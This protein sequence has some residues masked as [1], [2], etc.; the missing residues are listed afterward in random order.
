M[1]IR[2]EK[3]WKFDIMNIVKT[4]ENGIGWK[5][6]A[7]LL[8][9]FNFQFSIFTLNAQKPGTTPVKVSNEKQMIHGRKYYV[10]IVERGQTV[11]SISK[12]YKVSSYD[13]VTHVDI[14]ALHPGDTVWLPFRGQFADSEEQPTPTPAPTPTTTP[15]NTVYVHDTSYINVPYAVHDTVIVTDTV[16]LTKYVTVHDTTFVDIPHVVHDTAIVTN[17]VTQKEYVTVHDTIIVTD[18]VTLTKY[19]TVHD[20]THVNVPQVV[21]DT[22]TLTK[23]ETLRDTIIVKDTV[24]LTK[25][26]TVH[27]TTHVNV[28]QIVRDTVTLTKYETVHDTTYVNVPQV[29]HDTVTLTKYVTVH[30]TTHVNVPQVVRDT[31]TLTKYETVRDTVIVKDTVTLTQYVTVHDT[32][33]ID[34]PHVVH[35]TTVVYDTVTLT[36]NVPVHDTTYITLRD[37]TFVTDTVTLTQYVTVHDTTHVDIPHIVHD[38]TII[39][40]TVTLTKYVPVHDTT[41][42]DVPHDATIVTDTVTLTEYVSVHDTTYIDVHDTL[43]VIDTV[44]LTKSIPVHDTTYIDVPYAVHDTTF[45]IDTVDFA[46]ASSLAFASASAVTMTEYMPASQPNASPA[47]PTT[48][49]PQKQVG[50]TLKIALLMPLHLNE[51]DE[52][53]TTKFDIEQRGKKSYRQ[54]EFIEFYEGI[55]LALEQLPSMGINTRV[56]LNVVDVLDNSAESVEQAFLSHNVA[57]SDVV[58]ALLFRDAFA[59][60][61]ELSQ[62]AGIHIVNPMSTRSE[63]CDENSYMVKIQPSLES[64]VKAILDNMKYERPN[65][66][67]YVIYGGSAD[68]PILNELKHQLSERGDIKYTLFNWNQSS[69]LTSTL[70]NTPGCNV[71][72]IY[73]QNDNMRVYVSNLLN[74]L[75]AIKSNSPTLYTFS[76]WT[77]DYADVD[78]SQL[79]LLNYHTFTQNWDLSNSIHVDFLKKFRNRF[80]SEPTSILA[81]TGYDL[82]SY[83]VYGMALRKSK[84]WNE[85]GASMSS[86]IHP[87]RLERRR[88]GLENHQPQLYRMESLHFVPAETSTR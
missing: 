43:V 23:Y 33:H 9:L 63:I 20:T 17:T 1:G 73:E 28:P 8:V 83:I 87:L 40:D 18:T 26:V 3:K 31:M 82:T 36:K 46:S 77:R 61:A 70:K 6:L 41:Y 35:D 48:T 52:I 50:E 38:T 75:A 7:L 29:V 14:H 25:Y 69:K 4:I 80:G 62:K 68:K 58:V 60:A 72:S 30:D 21:R 84:F 44:T 67:L 55:L 42:I 65:A 16:T 34:V 71:I 56:E 74:R 2:K 27:D 51:I 22:V 45:V 59:K 11:Y 64:Q 53:S 37:T 12:A 86:L 57:Q 85:P 19:V 39:T 47:S 78:F 24:T 88:A 81:A 66:H 79:Q 32:A 76:D 15:V 54:F 5:R 49:Q 10:H 13:A